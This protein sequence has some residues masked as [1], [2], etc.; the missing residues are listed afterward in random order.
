M[1]TPLNT[2]LLRA[3]GVLG[4]FDAQHRSL[5]LGDIAER[6]GMHA[7][8]VH[9][10]VLTL[11]KIGALARTDGNRYQIGLRMAQLSS[12]VDVGGMLADILQP[13][14]DALVRI[15]RETV[16]AGVLDRNCVIYVAKGE[17]QRSLQ[18]P[19]RVGMQLPAY[20]SGLGKALLAGL[21]ESSLE[22][23]LQTMR[24]ERLTARTFTEPSLLRAELAK[25]ALQGFAIDD[26]EMEEGL[27]CLAVPVVGAGGRTVAALSVSGPS[28]RMTAPVLR[29]CRELLNEHA[30]GITQELNS[31]QSKESISGN[32]DPA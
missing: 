11:E 22:T 28:S 30:R 5:T 18:I 6:T 2:S 27:R 21:P 15:C 26:E 29:N 24:L 1:P 20:C 14:V 13:H 32:Q 8:T 16:H 23:Y 31:F 9:R 10:F 7:A 12:H 3:F 19:T 17:S 4:A 25:V